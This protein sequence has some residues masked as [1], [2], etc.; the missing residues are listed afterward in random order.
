MISVFVSVVDS[1]LKEGQYLK[2]ELEVRSVE[3]AVEIDRSLLLDSQEIFVIR[4]GALQ[5]IEVTP[6]H[7][8]ENTVIVQGVLD[9][10]QMLALPGAQINMPVKVIAP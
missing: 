8:N 4:D 6:I 10:E 3:D 9:G 1:E 5:L 7:F 2:T